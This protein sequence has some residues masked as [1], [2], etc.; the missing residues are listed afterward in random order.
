MPAANSIVR[1]QFLVGKNS[2]IGTLKRSLEAV[3]NRDEDRARKLSKIRYLAHQH[4]ATPKD[5]YRLST[6][7]RI[8][9]F[10]NRTDK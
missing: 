10:L 8:Y 9:K 2:G 6:N 3:P 7:K 5:I 1:A 4:T